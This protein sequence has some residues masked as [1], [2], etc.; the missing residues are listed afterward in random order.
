MRDRA[1]ITDQASGLITL[2]A[3][4]RLVAPSVPLWRWLTLIASDFGLFSLGIFGH[5]N[6]P[7]SCARFWNFIKHW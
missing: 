6:F 2:R 4:P 5:A 7:K 3:Q 1:E